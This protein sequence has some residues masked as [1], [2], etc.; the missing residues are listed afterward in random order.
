M[1]SSALHARPTRPGLPSKSGMIAAA[2][3]ALTGCSKG[4][5]PR[6]APPPPPMP[7]AK[8]GAC[9]GGGG[10]IA[11][12]VSAPYF[13]RTS[14]GYCLDPNGGDKAFGEGAAVG[15]EAV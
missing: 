11:D 1:R 7:A 14:G 12:A 3:I 4:E 5:E 6:G 8:A 13:P 2:L 10:K 9:A 15:I